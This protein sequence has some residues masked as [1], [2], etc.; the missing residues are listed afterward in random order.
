MIYSPGV[1]SIWFAPTLILPA[2]ASITLDRRIMPIVLI[3]LLILMLCSLW[4]GLKE[5][6]DARI[7]ASLLAFLVLIQYSFGVPENQDG[8]ISI[9]NNIGINY[10]SIWNNIGIICAS[11]CIFLL[12]H[13]GRHL[14]VSEKNS[15]NLDG[16]FQFLALP[17]IFPLVIIFIPLPQYFSIVNVMP[18]WGLYAFLPFFFCIPAVYRRQKGAGLYSFFCLS[19]GF[20]TLIAF[21]M[22]SQ[23]ALSIAPQVG[24]CLAMIAIF[25]A[26]RQTE[27]NIYDE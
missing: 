2:K 25:L 27:K 10:S 18:L 13:I 12:P 23:P 22:R 11:I 3:S 14:L 4:R 15:P 20:G 24:L 6:G 16:F 9:W 7:W 5:E 8:Q 26:P 1:P 19:I 21:F 17:A